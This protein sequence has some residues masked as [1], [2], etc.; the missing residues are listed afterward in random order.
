MTTDLVKRTGARHGNTIIILMAIWAVL[1]ITP[2]LLLLTHTQLFPLIALD[3]TLAKCLYWITFTGTAPYGVATVLLLLVWCFLLLPKKQFVSLAFA[4]TISQ[5]VSLNL[6]HELKSVFKE[7]RPNAVWLAKQGLLDVDRFYDVAPRLRQELLAQ[8]LDKRAIQQPNQA[9]YPQ[10]KHH[11]QTEVGFSFPSGHTIFAV[12]LVL[13]ASYY[14]LLAGNVWLPSLLTM[15]GLL[16]GYSRM[17]LGMHWPQDLLFSTFLGAAI[18]G[19]SIL[20]LHWLKPYY[21]QY[22][23]KINQ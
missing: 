15:W 10:I 20:L 16:M 13:T 6:S 18:S 11:W 22:T 3:S 5:I 12:T 19:L 23:N 4:V 17:L 8:A 7:P 1:A 14:L 9:F 21:R 2:A